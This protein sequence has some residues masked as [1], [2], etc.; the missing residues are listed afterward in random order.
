[1]NLVRMNL[2]RFVR[3]KA[4]YVLLIITVLITGL[5]ILDQK[6]MTEEAWEAEQELL[7]EA[8]I[9]EEDADERVGINLGS[10]RITSVSAMT[11]ATVGSGMILVFTGIFASL[12]SNAERN[13][14]Y[15][16]NLNSCAQNKGQIFIAK[17]APVAVF[18]LINMLIVPL[19]AA[20]LGLDVTSILSKEF[21]L[22]IVIQWLLHSAYGI[23]VLTVMEVSRSLVAGM[24]VGIFL[25]MGV[26]V[27]LLGF[28]E[29]V[30]RVNGLISSHMLVYVV[31]ALMM[32]NVMSSLLTAL[33][34]GI[35][36]F[37]LYWVVGTL[38]IKKRDMY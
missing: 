2:Y 24:L 14:G 34:T 32:E 6:N 29:N 1:M 7:Q 17:G 25:G 18:A 33:L 38:I 15:L 22:Y 27:M 12:F 26:G 35:I 5:I 28:I 31:R 36:S 30:V 11:E 3:T 16:K 10:S 21:L 37:V 9:S 8:G 20:V 13:G 23:F 19:T 4:V